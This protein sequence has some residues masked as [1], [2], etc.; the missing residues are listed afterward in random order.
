MNKIH[1]LSIKIFSAVTLSF[2]FVSCTI[3]SSHPGSPFIPTQIAYAKK[4][5]APR[6]WNKPKALVYLQ[7]GKDENLIAATSDAIREWNKT[8]AFTFIITNKKKKA[9]IVVELW[10]STATDYTGYTTWSYNLKNNRMLAA[11]IFL[12][13]YYLENYTDQPMSYEDG[14]KVI[15][16][17]L[18]HA[19]GLN[20][21]TDVPSIMDPESQYAIQSVDIKTV[22]NIYRK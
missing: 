7:L 3:S 21:R 8:K 1:R 17:E 12:N 5:T 13:Q 14:V 20:H 18:G 15:E 22:K 9:Q 6:R 16:H 4:K 10:Y 19:I 2:A 11:K